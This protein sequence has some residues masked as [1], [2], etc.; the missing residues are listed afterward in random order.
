MPFWKRKA[1]K[2]EPPK[3]PLR[4]GTNYFIKGSDVVFK[5]NDLDFTFEGFYLQITEEGLHINILEEVPMN[6]INIAGAALVEEGVELEHKTIMEADTVK[7]TLKLTPE[8]FE[9]A[10]EQLATITEPADVFDIEVQGK[11]HL[12]DFHYYFIVMWGTHQTLY[13]D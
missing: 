12:R 8:L 7:F 2:P 5:L 13:E 1:K 6:L 3:E 11:K 9:F 4:L 10:K